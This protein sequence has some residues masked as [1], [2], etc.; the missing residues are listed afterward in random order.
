MILCPY[1]GGKDRCVDLEIQV[2]LVVWYV[3]QTIKSNG[4]NM[5]IPYQSSSQ[6]GAPIHKQF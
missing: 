4:I 6:R 1:T 2:L 3:Y 5:C